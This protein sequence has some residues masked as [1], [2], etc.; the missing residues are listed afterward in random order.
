MEWYSSGWDFE[1]IRE[2]S[3]RRWNEENKIFRFFI[4]R[5]ES[6]RIIF[7]DDTRGDDCQAPFGIWEHDVRIRGAKGVRH[8]MCNRR[9]DD[10]CSFCAADFPVHPSFFL[11]ILSEYEGKYYKRLFQLKLGNRNLL[12]AQNEQLGSLQYACFD[13]RRLDNRNSC[14]TGDVFTLV[15]QYKPDELVQLGIPED[16]LTPYDYQNIFER[17]DNRD[18]VAMLESDELSPAWG[19]KNSQDRREDRRSGLQKKYDAD[20]MGERKGPE[21]SD[22]Q[23][24][25]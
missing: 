18:I 16:M 7:L 15:K 22:S 1:K 19:Y 11:T 13:V 25:F 17:L 4:K 6:R 20:G 10:F 9:F 12:L 23:V 21:S 2:V 5:G 14:A 3:S 24:P 8:Y